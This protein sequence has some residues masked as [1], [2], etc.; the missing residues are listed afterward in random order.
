MER[1]CGELQPR[2]DFGRL[3]GP[4]A[5]SAAAELER[6]EAPELGEGAGAGLLQDIRRLHDHDAEDSRYHRHCWH[7]SDDG[8]RQPFPAHSENAR[9][10]S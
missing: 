9:T 3:A 4:E 10:W 6:A 1:R 2:A 8:V 5:R 7:H